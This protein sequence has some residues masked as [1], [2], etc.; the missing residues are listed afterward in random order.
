MLQIVSKRV[1]QRRLEQVVAKAA[2]SRSR[3]LV[4]CRAYSIRRRTQA[5][6][7]KRPRSI[8][9]AASNPWKQVDA[10]EGT[11]WWN[12]VTHE[13]TAIGAPMPQVAS[14]ASDVQQATVAPETKECQPTASGVDF[15]VATNVEGQESQI[16]TITLG[17]HQKIRAE[18]GGMLYMTDGVVMETQLG[19]VMAGLKRYMTGQKL[20]VTDFAF[21]P[22]QST[23]GATSGQVALGT[24][25]PSKLIRL[26]LAAY[27]G[28]IICQKG[29]FVCGSHT[30]EIEMEYAK[31]MSVG[32]FGGEGFVLQKLQGEGDAYVKAGGVIIRRR[33]ANGELL[34]VS[35]G[36]IVAFETS[37]Q[38]DIALQKGF[39]NIMFGGEGLFLTTL[40]GPGEVI[41][42]GLPFDRVVDQIARRI[43]PGGLKL[44]LGGRGRAGDDSEKKADESNADGEESK[45]D[46]GDTETSEDSAGWGWGSDSGFKDDE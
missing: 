39:K 21:D 20:M 23:Q 26:S 38:Y 10:A 11:Y 35:S 31:K 6:A 29:A 24:D 41:L 42:Q 14:A 5:P 7:A 1:L 9:K 18:A 16:V 15:D 40:T 46:D 2:D 43:P 19:G 30:I 34:R 28:A 44:N 45:G 37:V 36:C 22:A 17:P 13:T 25:F 4:L 3:C 33:L 12:T 8:P 27:G 32:F